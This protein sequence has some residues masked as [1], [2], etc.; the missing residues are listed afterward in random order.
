MNEHPL[1]D[2]GRICGELPKAIA[3][4]PPDTRT[5]VAPTADR[6]SLPVAMPGAEE[7]PL[8]FRFTQNSLLAVGA[9]FLISLCLFGYGAGTVIAGGGPIPGSAPIVG[10]SHVFALLA[11]GSFMGGALGAVI[12]KASLDDKGLAHILGA[13]VGVLAGPLIVLI[14]LFILVIVGRRMSE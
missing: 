6:L 5:A 3:S 11:A 12:G 13:I 10:C 1:R 8:P 14:H 9:A 4:P 7:P 2:E